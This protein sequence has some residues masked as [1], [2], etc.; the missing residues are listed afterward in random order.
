MVGGREVSRL[1]QGFR[2]SLKLRRDKPASQGSQMQDAD[3]LILNSY[4][5]PRSVGRADFASSSARFFFERADGELGASVA[6]AKILLNPRFKAAAALA[7]RDVHK[8]VQN[9][10]PVAPGISADNE[11]VAETYAT[12]IGRDYAGASRGLR[13]LGVVGN[14]DSIN[15]QRPDTGTILDAGQARIGGVPWA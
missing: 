8:I 1:R 3:F 13:Q 5:F 4:F 9:Q 12:C 15:N 7:L 14:R 11:R 6:I 10:F 2:S